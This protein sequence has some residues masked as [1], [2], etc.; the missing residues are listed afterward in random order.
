MEL[1][2][3]ALLYHYLQDEVRTQ[4]AIDNTGIGNIPFRSQGLSARLTYGL[5]NRYF[6]DLNFG[7]TG[8]ENFKVGEQYGFFPS[9]ALGWVVSDYN[10][11]KDNITWLSFLKLR[12][13]YGTAGN[14]SISNTRFPYQTK[15][16]SNASSTWGHV[17]GGIN[18]TQLGADNLRWEV[19]LKQNA[20][21]D[22]NF[23]RDRLKITADVFRDIRDNIFQQKLNIPNVAGYITVPYGNV[24]SMKSY[25]TDGN[26]SYS[27]PINKDMDFTIR[28][29][30]T[31]ATNFVEHYDEAQ[32]PYPYLNRTGYPWS[33]ARLYCYGAF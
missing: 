14:A 20:G 27:Q 4:T 22:I 30:Y 15:V 1:Y 24:G 2:L 26:F 29:N 12:G 23:F 13:S 17:G 5:Q 9:I 21:I 31:F 16:N 10:W 11:I 28:G 6:V 19:S 32:Q 3:G 8:S 33:S 7:Y 18:I 25:G